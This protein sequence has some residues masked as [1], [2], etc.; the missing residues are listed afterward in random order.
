MRMN[1]LIIALGA[2]LSL[3]A[4]G[5][6]KPDFDASGNFEAEEIIVSTQQSGEILRLNIEEGQQ[7]DSNAVIGQIDVSGLNIQKEKAEAG[8]GQSQGKGAAPPIW[9]C[10]SPCATA[11]SCRVPSSK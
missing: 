3:S 1:K 2:A 10:V 8:H 7:L 9:R 4:C 5:N 6:N 11:R